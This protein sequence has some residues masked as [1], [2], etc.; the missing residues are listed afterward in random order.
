VPFFPIR[1]NSEVLAA[2]RRDTCDKA[3]RPQTKGEKPGVDESKRRKGV[4]SA[5]VIT[6]A[7]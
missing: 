1:T 3:R 2:R 6:M 4:R 5:I 7:G